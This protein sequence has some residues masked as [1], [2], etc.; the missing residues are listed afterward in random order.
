MQIIPELPED[1]T[2]PDAKLEIVESTNQLL[3]DML[4]HLMQTPAE[5]YQGHRLRQGNVEVI[6]KIHVQSK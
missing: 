2:P 5:E 1:P 6:V 4:K 3:Y